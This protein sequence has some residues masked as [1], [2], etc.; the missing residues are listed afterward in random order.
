MPG[1]MACFVAYRL[2]NAACFVGGDWRLPAKH[3]VNM[4]NGSVGH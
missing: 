2:P 3:A 4:P 1:V